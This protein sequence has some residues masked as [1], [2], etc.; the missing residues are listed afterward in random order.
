MS[1]HT[2]AATLALLGG[3]YFILE[4]LRLLLWYVFNRETFM[5]W[6]ANKPVDCNEYIMYCPTYGFRGFIVCQ[7]LNSRWVHRKIKEGT[8]GMPDRK[9]NK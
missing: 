2:F 9:P 6:W 5:S 4:G 3:F 1:D 7:T 8:L